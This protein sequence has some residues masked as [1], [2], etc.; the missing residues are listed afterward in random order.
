MSAITAAL[1]VTTM[2]KKIGVMGITMCEEEERVRG[3]SL[4]CLMVIGL[5]VTIAPKA[6]T[7]HDVEKKEY[8]V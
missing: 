5:I 3:R 2:V 7:Y 6:W 8:P 1:F 4:S